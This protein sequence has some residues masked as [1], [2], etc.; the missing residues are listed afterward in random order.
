[1][2]D[3]NRKFQKFTGLVV[4]VEKLINNA[5]TEEEKEIIIQRLNWKLK[6]GVCVSNDN[7]KL[8]KIFDELNA[9]FSES[10]NEVV[11]EQIITPIKEENDNEN[12]SIDDE[13]LN[14][15]IDVE[16]TE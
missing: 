15:V 9:A 2:N 3:L 11:E 13:E 10:E 6:R 16:T 8:G 5:K 1:M 12:L 14:S 4:N 7:S